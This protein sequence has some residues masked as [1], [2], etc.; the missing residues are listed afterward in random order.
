MKNHNYES[1]RFNQVLRTV[2]FAVLLCIFLF[3]TYKVGEYFLE[4]NAANRAYNELRRNLESTQAQPAKT[5]FPAPARVEKLTK[6]QL[7]K[8]IISMDFTE[9]QQR[10]PE[11]IA[12]IHCD[13]TPIDYPVLHTLDNEY[14]LKHLY[15]GRNNDRGS[16]FMDCGN[17]SID[18]DDNPVLYGHL[19]RDGSMF[20]SLSQYKSQKYYEKHPVMMLYTPEGDYSVELLCGTVVDGNEPFVQFNFADDAELAEYVAKFDDHSTF[21]SEVELEPGDRILTMCTCSYEMTNA[22]YVVIGRLVP[23]YQ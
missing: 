12:W 13:G 2:A 10:N 7:P 3:S 8:R 23:L 1:G 18:I 19:M 15:N 21:Q 11:V 4:H 6:E 20:A 16:I 14:Y 22:R 17:S 5:V 9:L